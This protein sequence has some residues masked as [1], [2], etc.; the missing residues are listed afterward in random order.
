M[1]QPCVAFINPLK[2]AKEQR[3]QFIRCFARNTPLP[4]LQVM[5]FV[6]S[7]EM[8]TTQCKFVLTAKLH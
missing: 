1:K 4:F 8:K 2:T 7:V 5:K 3:K 6:I